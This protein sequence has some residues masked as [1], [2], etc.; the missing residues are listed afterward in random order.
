MASEESTLIALK[1]NFIR[2]QVR[3]LSQPL[4]PSAKWKASSEI[5][6]KELEEVMKQGMS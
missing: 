5:P 1:A 2:A 4:V 3:I 6:E